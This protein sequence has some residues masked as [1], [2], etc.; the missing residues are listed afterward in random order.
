MAPRALLAA[1]RFA[2]ETWTYLAAHARRRDPPRTMLYVNPIARA[3]P[4]LLAALLALLTSTLTRS[5]SAHNVAED[6]ACCALTVISIETKICLG[7][8]GTA[9]M[10]T[11]GAS[12]PLIAGCAALQGVKC[13]AA[14]KLCD[15]YGPTVG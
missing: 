7:I 11:M 6:A 13:A 3:S 1:N 15:R 8:M 12:A 4:I 2:R 14:A 5:V 9:T 10:A